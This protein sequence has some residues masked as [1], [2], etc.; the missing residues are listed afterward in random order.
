MILSLSSCSSHACVISGHCFMDS[1][2]GQIF[3]AFH[4][5]LIVVS[6]PYLFPTPAPD[7]RLKCCAP[8]PFILRETLY[9][10]GLSIQHFDFMTS[11]HFSALSLATLKISTLMPYVQWI[12]ILVPI[13]T[14]LVARMAA[15]NYGM[16]SQIDASQRSRKHMMARK[17]V[18]PSFRKILNTFCQ[19]EKTL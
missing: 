12:T 18:L 10:W 3:C 19:V 5:G 6:P 11:T 9:L 13:C 2:I 14:W 7:R 4:L 15:S 17:F 16:A 8:S 1:G